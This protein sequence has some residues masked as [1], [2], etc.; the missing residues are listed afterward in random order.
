MKNIM[1]SAIVMAFVLVSC[2]QKSKETETIKTVTNEEATKSTETVAKTEI[3]DTVAPVTPSDY[4]NDIVICYLNLKNQ[5]AKD[6]SNGAAEK[7]KMLLASFNRFDT[8]TLNEKQKKEYLDIADDAKEHAEHIGANGDK[9]EHQREHFVLLSK[10]INDL[11]K[12]FGSNRKLY[13][14]YCPMA[15]EGKGAIWISE[16]KEIKNPYQGSKMLTCGS[17]KKTY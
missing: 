12:I 10:D 4:A 16:V 2:N 15:N 5:L 7:G 3:I 17:V 6:D 14:D 8:K 13:Q 1:L 9:L 11:I